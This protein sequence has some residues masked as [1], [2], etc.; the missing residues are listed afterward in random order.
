MPRNTTPPRGSGW[1]AEGLRLRF[2]PHA[3]IG[4]VFLQ[5]VPWLTFLVV[6]ALFFALSKRMMLQPGVVFELPRVRFGE[7]LQTGAS[8][9]MLRA[10][11][12]GGDETLVFFDDVRYQ[13]EEEEQRTALRADL[14]RGTRRPD[15]LQ[16]LLL[17]DRR[18]PHGDVMDLVE[19]ARSAGVRRVNVAIKPE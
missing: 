18:V 14:A 9:V 7:G 16:I 3:R 19:L 4:N 17:A 2:R 10:Q 5:L 8:L 15:G 13:M 1:R 11:R 6:L 12:E